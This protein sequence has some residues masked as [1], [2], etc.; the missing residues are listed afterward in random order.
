[1]LRR[2][3]FLLLALPYM[4]LANPSAVEFYR[5]SLAVAKEKAAQE[6][7]LY[8][9]DFVASWCMPCRWMDETTF[10]D[11]RVADYLHQN[12]IPV[13]VDIDDFD[14]Y[15]YKQQFDV[16]VL[17]TILIFNSKGKMVGKYQES[18]APSKMLQI[19]AEHNTS[20][21]RVATA[22]SKPPIVHA[23]AQNPTRPLK[24]NAPTR[25]SSYNT[26]RVPAQPARVQQETVRPTSAPSPSGG[27]GLYRFSVQHQAA[28]GFSVQVGVYGEYG[29]VIRE[30]AK[31]EK[32]FTE[33][34]I[35][36]IG[37]FN[38]KTVYKILVGAFAGRDQANT[39]R[40][41]FQKQGVPSIIKDLSTM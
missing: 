32:R 41:T 25:P 19:L 36:H 37:K 34:I 17:P 28:S 18:L 40:E 31:L 1:M 3:L 9:V 29:N 23:P 15:A 27:Q 4:A 16:R 30:V 10:S 22:R 2:F 35:V 6:G 11:Q 12:Y 7:K 20:A 38:G 8:F 5:G 39:L 14:G 21:N 33:P 13:K 24:V 26:D